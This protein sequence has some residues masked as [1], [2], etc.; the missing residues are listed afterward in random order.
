M[1]L[2]YE[3]PLVKEL[4]VFLFLHKKMLN[5]VER[6]KNDALKLRRRS[7]QQAATV[8]INL[9]SDFVPASMKIQ[10]TGLSKISEKSV[11]KRNATFYC[12]QMSLVMSMRFIFCDD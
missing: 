6:S 8:W 7:E 2:S 12:I 3:T 10:T 1:N 4:L 5:L 9:I 11:A